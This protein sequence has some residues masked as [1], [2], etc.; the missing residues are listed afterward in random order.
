MKFIRQ[1]ST[2]EIE[3]ALE[4]PILKLTNIRKIVKPILKKVRKKGDVALVKYA[5][6]YDHATLE[7]LLVSEAEVKAAE[8]KVSPKLKA[9]IDVAIGNIEKF[10]TK[11]RQR[12]LKVETMPGVTC[13]RRSVPISSVGLYVPGGTA[14]LFSTVI[15]L[16]I[17]AR[18]AG[19]KD[20]VLCTPPDTNGQIH[21]AIIYTAA[22][23]GIDHIVKAGGAQA[24]GAMAYGTES[25]PK[26]H[27]IFGPGNQY[28]TAA[29]Q[30]V[31]ERGIAIDLPAGPSEVAI[32][33]DN[34]CVPAFVAAD[35][36][37]QAEH[38]IDSQVLLVT[39]QESVGRAV[40][41]EVET[42]LEKLP[43]KK[44]AAEALEHSAIIVVASEQEAVQLLNTY[45]AEHLIL[46]VRKP[47][48]I[49][50]QIVNAGS[51][52][53][54]NYAPESAGDYASGTNHTLPTNKAAYAF[55]GVSLDSF[56]KNITYQKITEKGLRKLGPHVE[57]MAEAEQLWG[58]KNAVTLRLNH[59]KNGSA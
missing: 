37:S 58:H 29:K 6:E 56:V 59:L 31:A 39:T 45:A 40:L 1:G 24:I 11:Q 23:I 22:L 21:P 16:G 53:M 20:I 47:E 25:V 41:A 46:A 3:N 48:R 27:K 54:G 19:C 33:A 5:L 52:F 18:V 28:V 34:T 2:E 55:S 36:L 15:M 44:I 12:H 7:S 32:M 30:I 57:A 10:H 50:E 26:V 13:M 8:E 43:R 38:G 42:Q 14:P 4:R 51:I 17:P 9:A 49:A 35:L